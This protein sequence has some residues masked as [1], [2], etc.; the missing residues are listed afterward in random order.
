MFPAAMH[1]LIDL[2]FDTEYRPMT[3]LFLKGT[4]FPPY[5][6]YVELINSEQEP[7]TSYIKQNTQ[8]DLII[9]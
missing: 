3:N 7:Q 9:L 5:L 6:F 1:G 2:G 4:Q 8:S